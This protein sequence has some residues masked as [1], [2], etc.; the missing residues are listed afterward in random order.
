MNNT[1][2][3]FLILLSLIYLPVRLYLSICVVSGKVNSIQRAVIK[4]RLIYL[5]DK[6]FKYCKYLIKNIIL[7]S[8]SQLSMLLYDIWKNKK[9]KKTFKIIFQV[10]LTYIAVLNLGIRYSQIMLLLWLVA[11]QDW[12]IVWLC[13]VGSLGQ[14]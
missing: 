4:S 6:Q 1:W 3:Y 12:D 5:T 7:S 13:I 10:L 9:K 14:L 11:I 2:L 8:N